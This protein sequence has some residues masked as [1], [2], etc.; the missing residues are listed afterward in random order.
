MWNE[1]TRL[2]V[3]GYGGL[4]IHVAQDSFHDI[5]LASKFTK[6]REKDPKP[7]YSE[8]NLL[9]YGLFWTAR[10]P[11]VFERLVVGRKTHIASPERRHRL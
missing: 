1:T 4:N 7:P 10:K 5:D 2:Q 9:L 6:R 8:R 11:A 3:L